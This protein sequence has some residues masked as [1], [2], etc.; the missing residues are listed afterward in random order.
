VG[1]H[2]GM[3]MHTY[4]RDAAKLNESDECYKVWEHKLPT[5]EVES[6]QEVFDA[7]WAILGY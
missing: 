1:I 5:D 4:D 2:N 7:D 6:R 3:A